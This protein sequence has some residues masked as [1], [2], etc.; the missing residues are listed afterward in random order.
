M[1]ITRARGLN[2]ARSSYLRSENGEYDYVRD[3]NSM[4]IKWHH[5]WQCLDSGTPPAGTMCNS[6]CTGADQ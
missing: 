1:R 6:D 5:F 3:I 2:D 4:I